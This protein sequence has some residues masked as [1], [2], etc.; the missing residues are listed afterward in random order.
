MYGLNVHRAVIDASE[1]VSGATVH[2]V[3]EAYDEG[4]IIAQAEVN[5]LRQRRSKTLRRWCLKRNMLLVCLK[6][7]D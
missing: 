5:V 3:N 6:G 7:I 1:S 4:A 2:Y